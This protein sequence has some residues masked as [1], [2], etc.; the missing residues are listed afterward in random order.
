[1]LAGVASGVFASYEESVKKCV[2]KD[3]E[4][5]PD[6]QNREVYERG[7]KIYKKIHDALAPV[8]KEMADS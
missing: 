4:I 8:Y 5:T 7:F 1:M 6:P 2:Q 3:L